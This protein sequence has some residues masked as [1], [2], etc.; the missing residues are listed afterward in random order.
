MP[1]PHGVMTVSG[2]TKHSLCT[3]EYAAA[4]VAEA[5]SGLFKPSSSSVLK[6][7]DTAKRVRRAHTCNSLDKP[8]LV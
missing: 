4:L 5:R 2:N 8:E 7:A 1:G 6:T 3:K